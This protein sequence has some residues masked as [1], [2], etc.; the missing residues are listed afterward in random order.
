[1][2]ISA[3]EF[4]L[5]NAGPPGVIFEPPGRM[6]QLGLINAWCDLERKGIELPPLPRF[7]VIHKREELWRLLD[8]RPGSFAVLTPARENVKEFVESLVFS[9]NRWPM[10]A[11]AV[12]DSKRCHAFDRLLHECGIHCIV[13]S[14]RDSRTLAMWLAWHLRRTNTILSNPQRQIWDRLPWSQWDS[15]KGIKAHNDHDRD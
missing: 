6:W 15:R 4:W 5:Q 2:A 7:L 3:I 14:P 11:F 10:A 8:E 1:M 12:A 9:K 13:S